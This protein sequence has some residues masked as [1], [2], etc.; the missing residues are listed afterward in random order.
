MININP[1][2]LIGNTL[3]KESTLMKGCSERMLVE[4]PHWK[5]GE[6]PFGVDAWSLVGLYGIPRYRDKA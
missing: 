2:I 1:I 5:L 3:K 4:D 6:V